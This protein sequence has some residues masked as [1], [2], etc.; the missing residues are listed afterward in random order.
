MATKQEAARAAERMASEAVLKLVE[1]SRLSAEAAAVSRAAEE[2]KKGK[3]L[4]FYLFND[5]L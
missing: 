2:K 1:D 4:S 5:L 3:Y